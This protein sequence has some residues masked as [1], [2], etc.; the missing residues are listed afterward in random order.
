MT[1]SSAVIPRTTPDRLAL[2]ATLFCGL[3]AIFVM[4]VVSYQAGFV[5][6]D[7]WTYLM[8]AESVR[9]IESC[10][11]SGEYVAYH[12]CGYPAL[13]ALASV[14]TGGDLHLAAKALNA[15]F[16]AGSGWMVYRAS[17]NAVFGFLYAVNPIALAIA[18]YTWSENAFLAATAMVFLALVRMASTKGSVTYHGLLIAGLLLGVSSRYYFAPYALLVF[19][20]AWAIF[21]T[22][23]AKRVFPWFCVA[24]AVFLGNLA[25]NW[26]LTGHPTGLD[27]IPPPET[28]TFLGFSYIGYLTEGSAKFLMGTAFLVALAVYGYIRRRHIA[29]ES[30]AAAPAYRFMVWLGLS[31]LFLALILRLITQYDIYDER[32]V[33]LGLVFILSAVLGKALAQA[34]KPVLTTL[35]VALTAALSLLT[36][37]AQLYSDMLK[38]HGRAYLGDGFAAAVATY[39]APFLLQP[40]DIVLPFQLPEP[41]W[42]V[43]A[44]PTLYYPEGVRPIYIKTAPYFTRETD[45]ELRARLQDYGERCYFD[46][47]NV[48]NAEELQALLNARFPVD[49][50]PGLYGA[51]KV[52]ASEPAY[53]LK[54]ARRIEEIFKPKALVPCAAY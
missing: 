49:A 6:P 16:L 12:P 3:A 48:G 31:Y 25:L 41:K 9:S 14:L 33:G 19:I 4:V 11:I 28:I 24:A 22:A 17:N 34:G 53:D 51:P 7:S 38:G 43:A 47:Y 21:G 35:A 18:H 26:K 39:D 45:D 2:L 54:V 20:V 32:T 29:A 52:K 40:G 27:R 42:S 23:L 13:I 1:I 30:A 50:F 5:S 44:H 10:S 37:H 46:F 8:M 15:L 36:S